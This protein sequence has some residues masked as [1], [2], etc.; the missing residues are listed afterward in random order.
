MA[1]KTLEPRTDREVFELPLAILP[2]HIDENGHV[3]NVVYV[4]WLQ[5]AGTAH[6]NARF[7]AETRARWSWVALRHEIDYLRALMPD[8]TAV[9]RTW[10]G[11]PQGPRFAR[12]VRIEDGEGR[13][14]AQGVSEWC[15][16]EPRTMRPTRIPADMLPTFERR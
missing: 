10:V 5:D 2:E 1:R 3:N 4:G 15:L 11:D 12:Y 6:W 14:C 13:L 9:A 7:D 8:S 16:I